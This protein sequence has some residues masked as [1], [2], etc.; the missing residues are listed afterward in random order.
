L[1]HIERVTTL[2]LSD[3]QTFERDWWGN[4][5][6]TFSEE[7][8][9]ITYAHRMGLVNVPDSYT[10]RWP[11]Y[12]LQGKS[13]L[14]IG[15]GPASMLLKTVNGSSL[16]VVDPCPYPSWVST[17]YIEAGVTYFQEPA[18]DFDAG[19]TFDE[20]WIYNVLQHVEDPEKCLFTA[21]QHGAVVRVFEWVDTEPTLGH[22]HKLT[23]EMLDSCLGG[24]GTVDWVNEN[25][26]V[27]KAYFGAFQV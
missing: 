21:T 19:H 20:V 10:G 11:Q 14:D 9:Q 6:N 22:P 13:V 5:I 25:S 18:E 27:G 24:E 16:T 15:G 17:R 23:K 2:T 12:D 1:I 26:A 3:D 4:C 7:A 8:K